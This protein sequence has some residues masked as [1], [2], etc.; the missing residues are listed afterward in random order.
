MTAP[1]S[2]PDLYAGDWPAR[3]GRRLNTDEHSWLEFTAPL[4]QRAARTLTGPRLRAYFD[5]VLGTLPPG[6]ARFEGRLAGLADPVRRRQAQRLGLSG[7]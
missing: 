1:A 2:L 4:S 6:G 5:D 7:P 3:P